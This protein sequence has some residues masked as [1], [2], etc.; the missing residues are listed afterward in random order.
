MGNKAI[1]AAEHDAFDLIVSLCLQEL[2]NN[3]YTT[4]LAEIRAVL[5]EILN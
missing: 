3:I 1:P 5:D 2:G 4:L